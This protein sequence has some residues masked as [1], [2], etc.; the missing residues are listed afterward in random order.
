MGALE[1]KVLAGMF[2][3]VEIC[4]AGLT[5][6]LFE[7][8]DGVGIDGSLG[9]GVLVHAALGGPARMRQSVSK[10]Q[11]ARCCHIYLVGGDPSFILRNQIF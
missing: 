9:G 2:L 4:S 7:R 5:G 3:F 1:R 6:I 10:D 8:P 11:K